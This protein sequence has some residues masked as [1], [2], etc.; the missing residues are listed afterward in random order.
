MLKKCTQQDGSSPIQV[1]LFDP[2]LCKCV[3]EIHRFMLNLESASQIP[4][5]Y[6]VKAPKTQIIKFLKRWNS[7]RIRRFIA[8]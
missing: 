2:L 6:K 1:S 3:S 5:A 7:F 8:Q 4:T